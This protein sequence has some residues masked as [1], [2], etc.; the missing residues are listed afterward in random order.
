MFNKSTL[1]LV[2]VVLDGE[3][4]SA[5]VVAGETVGLC[6]AFPAGETKDPLE[7][8]AISSKEMGGGAEAISWL[9]FRPMVSTQEYV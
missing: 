9:F 1:L 3:G 2:W 5:T 4:A 6:L 8:E 7:E